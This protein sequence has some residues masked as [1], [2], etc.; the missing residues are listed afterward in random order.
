MLLHSLQPCKEAL[1][2]QHAFPAVPSGV[3]AWQKMGIEV[4]AQY[5]ACSL[6]I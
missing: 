2:E 6:S 5:H 3:G 4:L 1:L